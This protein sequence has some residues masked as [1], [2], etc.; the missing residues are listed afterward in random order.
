M[1]GKQRT[2]ERNISMLK[3]YSSLTSAN[4]VRNSSQ[5]EIDDLEKAYKILINYEMI[6]QKY[7]VICNN[8]T[9]LDKAILDIIQNSLSSPSPAGLMY[10]NCEINRKLFNSL[11]S[12]YAYREFM[13]ELYKE[14]IPDI[15]TLDF[16][17]RLESIT[18]SDE[19]V[20][21][22]WDMR[23]YYNHYG[24]PCKAIG[25]KMDRPGPSIMTSPV[26]VTLNMNFD[27]SDLNPGFK[28]SKMSTS[29]INKQPPSFDVLPTVNKYFCSW[30]DIHNNVRQHYSQRL[31]WA[32]KFIENIF[33][34]SNIDIH[35]GCH[36]CIADE[37]DVHPIP[38]TPDNL[39]FFNN[40][41]LI[42]GQFIDRVN[43][44][45]ENFQPTPYENVRHITLDP[46]K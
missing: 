39:A 6:E 19:L 45:I 1:K 38:N 14:K 40:Y 12:Y 33:I 17:K 16:L 22:G 8:N 23:H 4:V 44:Y 29:F 30:I 2:E 28:W 27:K 20:A 21:F 37:A 13:D 24:F 43:Y 7:S 25:L 36:L 26:V 34:E 41:T 10:S 9:D 15:S 42:H 31:E 5:K 46:G 18:N 32:K 35:S 11:S 3:L